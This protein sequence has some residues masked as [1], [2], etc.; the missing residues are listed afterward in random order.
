MWYAFCRSNRPEWSR[1][2]V[3]NTGRY[4]WQ[5]TGSYKL[6]MTD[7]QTGE[8]EEVD[9]DKA[10][11]YLS[12]GMRYGVNCCDVRG[13]AIKRWSADDVYLTSIFS[14]YVWN[15]F[16]ET[17]DFVT[18]FSEP[19]QIPAFDM[20]IET[21]VPVE[22]TKYC[23]YRNGFILRI[24]KI[25]WVMHNVERVFGFKFDAVT[26]TIHL[27]VEARYLEGAKER[28]G[29]RGQAYIERTRYSRYIDLQIPYIVDLS[30]VVL[31]VGNIN[32][33]PQDYEM[34]CMQ[35]MM[36][37]NLFVGAADMG[38]LD[39]FDIEMQGHQGNAKVYLVN[40]ETLERIKVPDK[41]VGY[42][43]SQEELRNNLLLA[44]QRNDPWIYGKKSE[45]D[46]KY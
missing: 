36:G 12:Q 16:N 32:I 44:F 33:N 11:E 46:D 26:S 31:R 20:S 38:K 45:L 22:K 39:Q 10:V 4:T 2:F 24:G 9:I 6:F 41:V 34:V 19:I 40:K 35:R 37:E 1:S 15:E 14:G 42:Y 43:Q 25:C 30:G 23:Y 29:Y 7:D 13:L 8:C 3:T 28:E 17:F 5:N 18:D 21:I 27:A